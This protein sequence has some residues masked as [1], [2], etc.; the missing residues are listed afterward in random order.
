MRLALPFVAVIALAACQQSPD[1]SVPVDAGTAT[2]VAEPA[3]P[4]VAS[5]MSETP[6]SEV[7][8]VT[9][10]AN[11]IIMVGAVEGRGTATTLEFGR[12]QAT[13]LA[14]MEVGFGKPRLTKL[15]ECGAGPME[16]A[17]WGPLTLNFL[18]G[19]FAGWRAEKGA[20]VVTVDGLQ[21]G[22]T[23][24]E[25]KTE[26][27]ARRIPGTTLEGEFEYASGDGGTIGGFLEGAGNA[28]QVASFH[29]G[30]SCFFR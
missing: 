23:L 29:A 9:L 25:I 13:T 10:T 1:R 14:V 30:T 12:D 18:G 8:E 19:K 26:R 5:A 16:F 7:P 6:A 4:P 17:A 22:N 21:L 2:A 3:A 15:A 11:G 27:S 20:Q 28:A 24:A